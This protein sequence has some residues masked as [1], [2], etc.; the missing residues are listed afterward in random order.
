MKWAEVPGRFLWWG[1]SCLWDWTHRLHDAGR[2]RFFRVGYVMAEK[3][4]Q[5]ALCRRWDIGDRCAKL[6]SVL[7][8]IKDGPRS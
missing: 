3:E 7:R 6:D 8:R 4:S 2:G 5:R 1:C